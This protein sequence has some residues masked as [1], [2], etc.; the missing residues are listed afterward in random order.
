MNMPS[1]IKKYVSPAVGGAKFHQAKVMISRGFN[2]LATGIGYWRVSYLIG[3][4]DM[5]RRYARSRLGQFWLVV[6]SAMMISAM[7]VCWSVLWNQPF[8]KMLPYVGIGMITWQFI[9]GVMT[10]ATTIF[11]SNS[12]YLINQYL[13]IS[14]IVYSMLYRNFITFCLNIIFP[15]LLAWISGTSFTIHA[16]T[17]LYGVVILCIMSVCISFAIGIL[18]SRFRDIIQIISNILQVTMFFTPVFWRTDVL[19]DKL[20]NLLMLNPFAVVLTLVRSPLIGE[21]VPSSYLYVSIIAVVISGIVLIP[22]IGRYSR[23]VIYWL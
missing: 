20:Q 4:G 17:S 19:S 1:K 2:E 10:D 23:R 14:A 7:G 22:F 9:S 13:P 6:S 11:I 3:S 12:H 21:P 5:R 16:L 15:I 18:C 8:S